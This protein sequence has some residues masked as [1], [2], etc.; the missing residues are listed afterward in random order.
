MQL[1]LEQRRKPSAKADP[2]KHKFLLSKLNLVDLA[3]ILTYLCHTS[4]HR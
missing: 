3:G 2:S 4:A 1:V